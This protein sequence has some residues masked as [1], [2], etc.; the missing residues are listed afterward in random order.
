MGNFEKFIKE[1]NQRIGISLPSSWT[2]LTEVQLA[3]RFLEKLN[4]YFFQTY[5]GI[6]ITTFQGEELQYFSEF[7]KFWEANHKEILNAKID[8]NKSRAAAQTLS[9]AIKKYGKEILSV[10][11]QTQ[12]LQP[13]AI[14]Q[15]RF[16]TANQDFRGS[17][18][19]PYEKYL[20]DPTN[21][22]AKE[23][24]ENPVDFLKF[25]EMTR[26]SQNDK[27]QDFAKN[28]ALFL[29]KRNISAF[30]I[31]KCFNND[32]VQIRAALVNSPNMGYGL[33]KANMFIRDM[34]ELSV[35]T[36]LKNFEKIDVA[37]DIN[38]M[39]L[40]LRTHILQTDIPL[41][42]SFLDIFCY[43]YS[44]IDVM[45]A[46]AW[47]TVWEKWVKLDPSTAPSSPSQ[48]DF[49][50][51]RIGRE[52]C[53]DDV[54]EYECARGHVFYHFGAQLKNCLKCRVSGKRTPAQPK[55][56]FLPCQL[57]S[58]QL[59]RENGKLLLSDDNLLKTFDGVCIFEDVCEPKTKEFRALNPPKSISIK[60]Q[61]SWT[62]SYAYRDKG[63]G[64]MMG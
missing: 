53:D 7:H 51:Y 12:G 8:E 28:A 31:A 16:F 64:G 49:L 1:I 30:E 29:L 10:T 23:I 39:K 15:V 25:L 24:F 20:Q 2:E 42:S 43:Q 21:F 22:D 45:S 32:A 60:G 55:R 44:H 35:W 27:R 40:A 52:Y 4:E 34:V 19:N 18:V 59:P 56:R 5:E 47:R 48:M 61:T 38:T 3:Q 62:K 54:V 26:L 6:G 33:K 50:L 17:P 58:S 13:Q 57:N 41:L 14:A 63:G 46:I 36:E 9:N 11:H 37:S